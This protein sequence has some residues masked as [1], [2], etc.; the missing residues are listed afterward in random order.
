MTVYRKTC[1][2]CHIAFTSQKREARFCGGLCRKKYNNLRA[3]RGAE[4]YDLMMCCRYDREY[5]YKTKLPSLMARR[6]SEWHNQDKEREVRS[7]QRPMNWV[8]DNCAR[9]KS[10]CFKI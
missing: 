5:A 9:L 10:V 7:W 1:D 4:L 2:E 3:I 8:R 6:C